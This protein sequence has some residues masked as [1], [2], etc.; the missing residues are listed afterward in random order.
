MSSGDDDDEH[1]GKRTKT[2]SED[3]SKDER[4]RKAFED[5]DHAGYLSD[6]DGDGVPN[7]VGAFNFCVEKKLPESAL[8]LIDRVPESQMHCLDTVD[9]RDGD[10]VT[11][12]LFMQVEFWKENKYADWISMTNENL[13]EL[14][15]LFRSR[16]WWDAFAE[17]ACYINS[18]YCR[19]GYDVQGDPY[20]IFEEALDLDWERPQEDIDKLREYLAKDKNDP[21]A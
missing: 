12:E 7:A 15:E 17:M 2:D 1:K 14:V 5:L 4:V 10:W 8:S 19:S 9:P 13:R 18:T 16:K 11:E 21:R 20:E 3:V 6:K